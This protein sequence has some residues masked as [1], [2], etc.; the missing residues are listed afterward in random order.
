MSPKGNYHEVV[1]IALLRRWYR[2]APEDFNIAPET[3]FR[4]SDDTYLE[5]D[6]VVHARAI[7]LKGLT[8]T[9][10]L[11]V[12][13]IAGSSL[14]YD[15]GRK[16][17]LYAAFGN[18]RRASF[19]TRARTATATR[20]TSPRPA[21]SRR[22]SPQRPS[23]CGSTSWSSNSG[24]RPLQRR[25]FDLGAAEHGKKVLRAEAPSGPG[26]AHRSLGPDRESPRVGR[27]FLGGDRAEPEL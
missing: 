10:V 27:V 15:M 14:S 17:A 18:S 19:A 16:A 7:G 21:P 24:G 20:A 22:P 9:N 11:L 5:P 6:V 23:R 12:V 4:L 25:P 26:G 8:G 3:T 1:K 13:E 2:A